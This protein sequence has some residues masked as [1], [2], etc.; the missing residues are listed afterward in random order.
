M[1]RPSS[2]ISLEVAQDQEKAIT[3]FMELLV[4]IQVVINKPVNNLEATDE[5]AAEK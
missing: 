3:I 4:T 2:S 5:L 1:A